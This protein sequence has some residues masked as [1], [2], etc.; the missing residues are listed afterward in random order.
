MTR[1]IPEQIVAAVAT[2]AE[3]LAQWCEDG[4]DGRLEEHEAAVL[5][6]VR[7]V[8][9]ALLEAVVEAATSGLAPR[10]RGQRSA[11]P[12]CGRKVRPHQDRPRQ[13]L[14]RCGPVRVERPWYACARCHHG[15]SVVETTLGVGSRQRSSAGL[16]AW[17]VRLGA[18]TDYREAAELL[19]ELTGLA[20]GAETIRRECVRI[21]T[22]IRTAETAAIQQTQRTREAAEPVDHAP[23]LL[24]LEADGAMI[25]FADGWHEVKLGMV[26]G[27]DGGRLVSPSYVAAR[28]SA[29]AF[30]P[31][32]AT[33]AARR[34]ALE[35]ERWEGSVTRRSLAVLRPALILADGA[36]WIWSLAD[37]YVD[38]R[39]EVSDFYHAV[40]H[41]AAVAAACYPDPAEA[42]TWLDARTGDL[43]TQGP[44]A[45][46]AA[47]DHLTPPTTQ[48]AEV[49]RVERAYFA[50]RVDRMDY[51][52][53]RLD[54][55]PIGS[56]AI[57]SAANHVVQRRMKRAGMRW[58][59]AGGDAML[60]LR[61]RHRSGR[62]L[63][64]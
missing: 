46:L 31:R 51:P 6:R 12:Q 48:A 35:V 41:L 45:V 57:E 40:E 19:D 54:G 16:V 32:L 24:V 1:A 47:F 14:T 28:E 64:A 33:E 18:A 58:S 11:C 29:T 20:V 9:P 62:P 49:R 43:L 10:V 61:A 55:L 53:L 27:W 5:E 56:G 30:G 3:S 37:E 59:D 36:T 22:A 60:A 39:I 4:R 25:Q 15:W 34:G 2:L 63:A 13:V 17:L 8:L 42:T 38:Q 52:S 50:N 26:A 23:G 7:Q 44:L 21:G